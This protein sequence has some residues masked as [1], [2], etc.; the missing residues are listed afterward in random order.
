[1]QA[2]TPKMVLKSAQERRRGGD[3]RRVTFDYPSAFV[4]QVLNDRAA[5]A[6]LEFKPARNAAVDAYIKGS[7]ISVRRAPAGMS[8]KQSA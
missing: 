4:T 7:T 3:R 8:H 1:M 5:A 6:P 2:L